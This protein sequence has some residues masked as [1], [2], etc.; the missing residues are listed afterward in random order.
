M[1]NSK[2]SYLFRV[3]TDQQYFNLMP[4]GDFHVGHKC[5]DLERF[6]L[7]VERAKILRKQGN[8]KLVVMGDSIENAIPGSKSSP[9]E[10]S[11]SDPE[12][13]IEIATELLEP[14]ADIILGLHDG[15]HPYRTTQ[16]TGLKPEKIIAKSLGVPYLDHQALWRISIN[17][18][19][20]D[21]FSCHG[22]GGSATPS[23]KL[24]AVMSLSKLATADLYLMG[25][26]HDRVGY[27]IHYQAIENGKV[28]IKE[29]GFATSASFL[30]YLGGYGE[31]LLYAPGAIG[32][33]T[34]QL[35]TT[36][37]GIRILL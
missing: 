17:G 32:E 30:S 1:A 3:M 36:E 34:I 20:Y 18:I 24:N 14:I 11:I 15:N 23:G 6:K 28:V 5:F 16:A 37:F 12:E 29:R 27:I 21:V 33:T 7:F 26:V 31:R 2:R 35:N 9:F 4:V 10:S 25:H 22:R 8:V 19:P 13:Q